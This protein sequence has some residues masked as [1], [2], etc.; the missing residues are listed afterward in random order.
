MN[1]TLT[2][3]KW[4][5]TII[6]FYT[7]MIFAKEDHTYQIDPVQ[8]PPII[9]GVLNDATWGSCQIANDFTQISPYPGQPMTEKV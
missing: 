4:F 2:M 1:K 5:I 3:K 9:D 7:G 8:I 6:L